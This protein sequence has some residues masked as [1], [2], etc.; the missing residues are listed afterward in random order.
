MSIFNYDIKSILK[1]LVLFRISI[2]SI[3]TLLK[4]S[5]LISDIDSNRVRPKD[6]MKFKPNDIRIALNFIIN[7]L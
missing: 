4:I 1:D 7:T 5:K 3:K 2:K 6:L